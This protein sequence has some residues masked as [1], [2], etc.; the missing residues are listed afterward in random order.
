M[1]VGGSGIYFH[2][3]ENGV[4]SESGARNLNFF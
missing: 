1:I 2:P 4:N 3:D